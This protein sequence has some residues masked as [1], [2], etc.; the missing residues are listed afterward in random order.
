LVDDVLDLET[1]VM[2]VGGSGG[3]KQFQGSQRTLG[4][5]WGVPSGCGANFWLIIS[6][7]SRK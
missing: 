3:R 4:I 2:T 5:Q 6:A 1:L 7:G